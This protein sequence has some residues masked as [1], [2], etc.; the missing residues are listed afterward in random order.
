MP[1]RSSVCRSTAASLGR[2]ARRRE[3]DDVPLAKLGHDP[4][5]PAAPD[6]LAEGRHPLSRPGVCG[7]YLV[8][9]D[10]ERAHGRPVGIQV[11][12]QAPEP[13]VD[14]SVHLRHGAGGEHGGQVGEERL[15]AQTLGEGAPDPPAQGAVHEEGGDQRAL[16]EEQYGGSDDQPPVSLPGGRL[17]EQD[18]ASG[19]KAP[20][21]EPPVMELAPVH[22]DHGGADV[23][24]VR[25]LTREDAERQPGA[26]PPVGL[27]AH[28]AGRPH[29]RCPRRGPGARRRGHE[30]RELFARSRHGC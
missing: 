24:R 3:S 13:G 19:R 11:L 14:L 17:L 20:L 2:S 10:G 26:R 6:H 30:R 27:E 29:F 25:P 16:E 22:H 1:R 7:P 4:R 5:R 15:E 12:H 9:R 8:G 21:V 23:R 18:D 28:H